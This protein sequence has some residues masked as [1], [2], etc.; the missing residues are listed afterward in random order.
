M[1]KLLENTQNNLPCCNKYSAIMKSPTNRKKYLSTIQDAKMRCNFFAPANTKCEERAKKLANP[2]RPISTI[3]MRIIYI[4]QGAYHPGII[5][6]PAQE[7]ID[8]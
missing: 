8:C 5:I 7:N 4:F 1:E 2:N 6:N 3:L